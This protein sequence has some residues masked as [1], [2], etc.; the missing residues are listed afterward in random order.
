M[1]IENLPKDLNEFK[2]LIASDKL[3]VIDFYATWCA[4]CKLISPKFEKL[5]E[6]YPDVIFAKIDV[7]DVA[8]VAA[9]V[10]VRAMPT[11]M[12]FKN[13]NKVDEVVGANLSSIVNKIKEHS[14]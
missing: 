8:D 5:V 11:F 2:A 12:F 6:E 13:S 9:E 10:G 14:A 4:P 3:V 7:D 1:A